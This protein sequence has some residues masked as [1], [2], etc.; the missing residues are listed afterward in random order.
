MLSVQVVNN[1]DEAL[2]VA[3]GTDSGLIACVYTRDIQN[4]LTL[5]RD[6]DAGQVTVNQY[7]AGGIY[8]AFGGT[9][10]SGFG[11]EKGLDAL[12]NYYRVNNTTSYWPRGKVL[13]GSSSINA[14]VYIRGHPLI[15][16]P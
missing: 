9:K 16:A 14:M 11:R 4:A 15:H 8:T 6:I 7:Y 3:N 2:T 1:I 12:K 5:A 10:S 13:G